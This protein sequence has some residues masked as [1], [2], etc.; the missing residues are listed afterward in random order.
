ME[1]LRQGL[2]WVHGDTMLKVAMNGFRR[3]MVR[4]QGGSRTVQWLTYSPFL[5]LLSPAAR[6]AHAQSQLWY[7]SR[8]LLSKL[9][10]VSGSY[11]SL[12][13]LFRSQ[14]WSVPFVCRRP[15]FDY[16]TSFWLI[17]HSSSCQ[18]SGASGQTSWRS[19]HTRHHCRRSSG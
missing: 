15:H 9:I 17:R 12:G 14:S 18:R 3:G 5:G 19:T 13:L 8:I 10:E 4:G 7:R 11:L 1:R 16:L 2:E 6:V